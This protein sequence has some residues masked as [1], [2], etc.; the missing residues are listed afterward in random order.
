[1]AS[2]CRSN[3]SWREGKSLPCVVQA[4]LIS[5]K[6]VLIRLTSASSSCNAVNEEV[7]YNERAS[8]K[9][10]KIRGYKKMQVVLPRISSRGR[11]RDSCQ[12]ARST[13]IT[14]LIF[15]R[16]GRSKRPL[17]SVQVHTLLTHLFDTGKLRSG[18]DQVVVPN[19]S[20][21]SRIQGVSEL[22]RGVLTR[23]LETHIAPKAA[24]I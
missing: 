24:T 7:I 18:H 4:C 21:Y 23:D 15:M 3:G 9:S 19:M 20:G 11:M 12:V 2:A 14:M 13:G 22:G 1:M 6:D 10:T 5:S 8:L 17:L 16:M